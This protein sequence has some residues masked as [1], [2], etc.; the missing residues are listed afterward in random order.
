VEAGL[1]LAL[2]RDDFLALVTADARLGPRL[3]D[4]YRGSTAAELRS[5]HESVSAS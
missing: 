5:E 4:L 3:L 2:D 1:L